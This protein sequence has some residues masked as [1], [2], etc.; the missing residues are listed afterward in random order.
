MLYVHIKVISVK[1]RGKW[2][3]LERSMNKR[4]PAFTVVGSVTFDFRP[5]YVTGVLFNVSKFEAHYKIKM[6]INP[7]TNQLHAQRVL[8]GRGSKLSRQSAHEGGK[9]VSP[10]HRSPSPSYKVFLVL[11]SVTF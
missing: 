5:L 3:F 1:G 6:Q 2:I 11:I 10:T 8:G 9:V 4:L 7:C